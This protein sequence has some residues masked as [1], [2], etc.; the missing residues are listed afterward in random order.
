[1]GAALYAP[2]DE[3]VKRKR[4]LRFRSVRR[5]FDPTEVEG[6]LI[7]IASRIEALDTRLRQERVTVEV[8]APPPA[9]DASNGFTKRIARLDV[10]GVREI[11]RMLEEAKEEAATIVSEA[12]SEADRVTRDA[13]DGA[14]RSV[15]ETRAFL[16]QVEG[17]AGRMLSDVAERRRQ[18]VEE[19][20]N[21][22]GHLLS[23]AQELNLVVNPV[24][25]DADVP[26]SAT[27]VVTG[28]GS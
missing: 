23:V 2:L 14:R 25:R 9:G 18:L 19:F 12:R 20:R 5:G 28:A 16:T 21:M 13:Q 4:S 15:D 7:T 24:G 27:S 1:M 6:F 22:H 17:D 26:E 3:N 11:K 10:V 8:L